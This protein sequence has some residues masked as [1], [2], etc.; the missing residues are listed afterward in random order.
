MNKKRKREKEN[1]AQRGDLGFM[2][3]WSPGGAW[4]LCVCVSVC[5]HVRLYEFVYECVHKRERDRDRL[6]PTPV[7]PGQSNK[8]KS[9]R[10][11]LTR[12]GQHQIHRARN[13]KRETKWDKETA[14][15]KVTEQK[16]GTQCERENDKGTGGK[17]VGGFSPAGAICIITHAEVDFCSQSK[18][19]WC[20][21]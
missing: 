4:Q 20:L 17:L 9:M 2:T 13:R 15:K 6:C 7:L 18:V 12:H 3:R 1:I 21:M 19:V 5:V 16:G 11:Q 8:R 14:C 10:G